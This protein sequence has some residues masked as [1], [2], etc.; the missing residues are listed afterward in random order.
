MN[1][2]R[3]QNTERFCGIENLGWIT[4]DLNLQYYVHSGWS[5]GWKP[6]WFSWHLIGKR[7]CIANQMI[8]KLTITRLLNQNVPI[9]SF[10]ILCNLQIIMTQLSWFIKPTKSRLY[11]HFLTM[12]ILITKVYNWGSKFNK[13]KSFNCQL[14]YK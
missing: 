8:E 11:Y 5:F 13:K 14:S 9:E 6:S 7:I 4:Y 3:I 1:L 2:F 10:K 12:L